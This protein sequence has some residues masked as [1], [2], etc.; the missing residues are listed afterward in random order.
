[1][2][3]WTPTLL[4]LAPL[5][6]MLATPLAGCGPKQP[7]RPLA[8]EDIAQIGLIGVAITLDIA[9][10]AAERPGDCAALVLTASGLE[11]IAAGLRERDF[12]A[13][14]L[15]ASRCG[16][17]FAAVE[18]PDSVIQGLLTAQRVLTK[19]PAESCDDRTLRDAAI[20]Y[21]SDLGASVAYSLRTGA[22]KIH[23]VPRPREVCDG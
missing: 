6:V 19:L 9:A 4:L 20:S 11:A 8:L 16:F 5:A 22:V 15:D 12:P 1:M 17:E 7:P 21:A 14:D 2:R 3:T 23:I 18:V 10:D 13:A